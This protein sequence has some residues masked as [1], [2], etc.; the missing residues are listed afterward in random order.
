MARRAVPLFNVTHHPVPPL[1]VLGLAAVSILSPFWFVGALAW[2][3]HIVV[4][5]A[6]GH[7]LRTAGG[8][9]RGSW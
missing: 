4:D 2:F 8:W 6:F 3:S 1:V 9:R 7:G 5:R